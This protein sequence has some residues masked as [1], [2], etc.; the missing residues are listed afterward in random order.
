MKFL[1]EESKKRAIPGLTI[2]KRNQWNKYRRY[3][4]RE[5]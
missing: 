3:T 5:R 1:K 2:T 4:N